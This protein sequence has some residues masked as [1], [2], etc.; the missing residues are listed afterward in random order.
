MSSIEIPQTVA[1]S[2]YAIIVD[3]SDNVAVVKKSTFVDLEVLLPDG[4]VVQLRNAVP[5]GHRF[6]TRAIPAREFVLQ[7]GQPIGTSLGIEAGE[8]ITHANMTNE[9]PIV[10]DLPESLHTPPPDYISVDDRATFM[11]YRRPDGR[12]GTRNFLLIVP[13]SMCASHE[14]SQIS[15]IAEYTIYSR[16]KYPNVDGIVAIPHNKGCG[17][18]D[19]STIDVMLRTL[20]NY[21]DHPNV[22]GVILI[23]LGCEKT[24]LS[25]VEKYLLKREKSFDKPVAKIGI[26]EVGGTQAAI[27]QGLKEVEQM[28]PEVNR[29]TREECSV[30]ELV[31]GVKCGGSDGFSGISA[32]PSLGRAA[33]LLVRSGGTVLITEVP[34]FCGAE[35]VLAQRAK[36]ADTA[37]EIYRLVDW[38]KEYA[39]K[40]GAVLN[41]NPSPGNVTGGLLNITIKSLGAIA[42]AGTTR[43]EGVVEYAET[44]K[45]RG[46]NLMQGPGYD[47]ESTPGLVAAG[48]TVVVFTTGRGTTIGN[49]IAPVIK[50]ASNSPIFER[51][52]ND[53]DLSA[54]GVI[55]G[56]ETI[57]EVGGRVFAHVV[58]VASGL[59]DKAEQHKHREFQFW[60]EQTVS[61]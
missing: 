26:Q 53:L 55:D 39:S 42:K 28:L 2:D 25:Q 3:A 9:V 15:T 57:Y 27:Q 17:C 21:A 1:I 43:V 10:R 32:N 24:N 48:A 45:N 56:T 36:D 6:A 22:G 61:L 44:P 49:A 11:G 16:Q 31:L 19:G 51:M 35:H 40:F 54:G 46:V 12:V 18:Q 59:A 60:A 33:D 30:S 7:F 58:E 41:Q 38:Y 34:E 37:R 13:T 4:K 29:T 52:A 5:P 20:S 14:A 47:Q 8:Q 50:L 23:D